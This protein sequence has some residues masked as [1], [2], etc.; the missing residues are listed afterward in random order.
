MSIKLKENIRSFRSSS[1]PANMCQPQK[2]PRTQLPFSEFD[3]KLV[4]L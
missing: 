3:I 4:H 1:F 2:N